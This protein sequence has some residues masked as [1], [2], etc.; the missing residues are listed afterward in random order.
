MMQTPSRLKVSTPTDTTIVMTRPFQAPRP[1]VWD[2][3]T[4]PELLKRWMFCPPGW[5]W[6]TWEMDV[7][8]GGRF[9]WAWN[10]PDGRLA[11]SIRG[12]YREVKPPARIV[13]TEVMEMGPGAGECCPGGGGSC[14]DEWE[15]LAALDLEERGGVT[16]MTMTLSFATKQARDGALA[17]GMEHGMEAGYVAMDA[18]L[19]ETAASGGVR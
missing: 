17:S 7:R 5:V 15:L 9:H 10:G 11:L 3:M 12:E 19:A 1:M 14:P 13:H 6:A 16:T 8:V 18:Y 2:A 4:K